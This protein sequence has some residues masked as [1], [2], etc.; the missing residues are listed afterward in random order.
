M[1]RAL[2]KVGLHGVLDVVCT[3]WAP[4]MC[5]V[6]SSDIHMVGNQLWYGTSICHLCCLSQVRINI[7]HVLQ[8]TDQFPH[9]KN[10]YSWRYTTR[11]EWKCP[12]DCR[13]MNSTN[14]VFGGFKIYPCLRLKLSWPTS[15]IINIR[16][17]DGCLAKV[18]LPNMNHHF[19][20]IESHWHVHCWPSL[21]YSFADH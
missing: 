10:H 8:T 13:G 20:L 14:L 7:L 11:A 3:S 5:S 16:Y 18:I 12:H 9:T 19:L 2:Q 6:I 21:L 15:I 4:T 17:F 1:T